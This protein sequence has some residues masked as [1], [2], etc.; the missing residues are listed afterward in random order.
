MKLL[1]LSVLTLLLSAC[2][3]NNK[4]ESYNSVWKHCSK[5]GGYSEVILTNEYMLLLKPSFKEILLFKTEKLNN[6]IVLS[7]IMNGFSLPNNTDTLTIISETKD[8]I[9]LK[10]S[11]SKRISH[12]EKMNIRIN[13]IDSL[14]LRKW[15]NTTLKQLYE[16]ANIENCRDLRTESEKIIHEFS[17]IEYNEMNEIEISIDSVRK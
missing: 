15:K 5:D 3:L 2:Q 6:K 17:I 11:F 4:N 16:R 14:N 9:S 12:L 7:E 13:K 1:K 8:R 10:Q